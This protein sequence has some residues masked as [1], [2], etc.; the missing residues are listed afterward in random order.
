MNDLISEGSRPSWPLEVQKLKNLAGVLLLVSLS[1][2]AAQSLSDPAP[3]TSSVSSRCPGGY[4][5]QCD[6][7]GGNQFKKRYGTCGCIRRGD[8]QLE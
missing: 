5:M 4:V 3:F 6:V 2:C 8:W 1:G 7:L